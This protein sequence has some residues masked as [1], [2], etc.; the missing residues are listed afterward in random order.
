MHD[1]F[2]SYESHS[3]NIADAICSTL[4]RNKI[5]C[6][7]APRDVG[8]GSYASSI[9]EAIKNSKVFV[10][11]L[12]QNASESPHVLNE[13]ETAY[14]RIKD[15]LTIIP[16]KISEN[17]SEEM[18][19][20]VKR[21]HWIDAM[22]ESL[23]TSI[24]K[25]KQH[26]GKLV[27]LEP[28]AVKKGR[29]KNN[30]M[31]CASEKEADRLKC[32]ITALEY[33][34]SDVYDKLV[35]GRSG[36][37]V[38]DLG[39]NRGEQIMN[40]LGKR[41]EVDKI[42]G[43]DISEE[44][45]KDANDEYADTCAKFYLVDCESESFESKLKDIMKENGIEAFDIVNMSHLLHNMKC[46]FKALKA[47]KKVLSKDGV[48]MII[49]VDDGQFL[50]HP[51]PDGIFT[52]SVEILGK[53]ETSGYRSNGRETHSLL[54]RVGMRNIVLEKNGLS[55]AGMSFDIKECVYK[56]YIGLVPIVISESIFNDPDNPKHRADQTWILEN[57]DELEQA[58]FGEEFFMNIGF[59]VYTAR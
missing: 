38:L 59:M 3:K 1:V 14:K 16:F 35:N 2:I 39:S 6:W 8:T 32:Q 27:G 26:V 42:I 46:P 23:E 24:D 28:D 40:M 33:F 17:V 7:Y 49:D 52:R 21:I 43:I 36:L 11:V 56:M 18:E 15:G 34:T 44:V 10:L 57:M 54:K 13:V 45:V 9:I 51:D 50:A 47:A 30:Y 22:T 41:P 20:Y 5:R 29:I 53:S 12:N 31:E 55:T 19:Y 4:E 37:R 25:L 58:F 48:F